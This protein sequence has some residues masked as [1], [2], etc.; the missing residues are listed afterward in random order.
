MKKQF[1]D[2]SWLAGSHGTRGSMWEG[3]DHLLVVEARGLYFAFSEIYR[4]VD[5]RNIQTIV[6]TRTGRHVGLTFLTGVGMLLFGWFAWR[7]QGEEPY[8]PITLG[9]AAGL[10]AVL[11]VMHLARGATCVCTLQTAV[12]VLKLKPLRHLRTALPVVR[13]LEELCLEHQRNLVT[14]PSASFQRP[15]VSVP[16][17]GVRRPWSGSGFVLISGVLSLLW[18]LFLATELFLSSP[19][20]TLL[21]VFTGVASTIFAIV[22]LVR[23]SDL[24]TPP[25]LAG[26]LWAGLAT[27]LVSAIALYGFA[28]ASLAGLGS[29]SPQD[30]MERNS[31]TSENFFGSL[32][33]YSFEQAGGL[34]W[35]LVILGAVLVVCGVVQLPYSA[36][37]V[38][39]EPEAAPPPLSPP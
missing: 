33:A 18:G 10:L 19:F 23:T 29:S 31:R 22:A 27:H 26:A 11:T 8:L 24:M 12:Q 2:Y 21:N 15:S 32:P 13:R 35:I 4:R 3:P 37:P 16:L 9:L 1:A 36:R 20:F 17:A 28:I 6:V 30:I 39:V 34:G 38:G 25:P 5:Y 14:D 7:T